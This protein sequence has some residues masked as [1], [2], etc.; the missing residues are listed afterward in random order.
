MKNVYVARKGC[1]CI[2]SAIVIQAGL[3]EPKTLGA[4]LKL[5]AEEGLVMDRVEPWEVE[6]TDACPHT[7]QASYLKDLEQAQDMTD[8]INAV[9]NDIHDG[10]VL[11]LT[12]SAIQRAARCTYTTAKQI[13]DRMEALNVVGPY[14]GDDRGQEVLIW[15]EPEAGMQQANPDPAAALDQAE[16][17]EDQPVEP[18]TGLDLEAAAVASN[19]EPDQEWQP[20]LPEID[21]VEETEV[22]IAAGVLAEDGIPAEDEL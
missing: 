9:M 1:G 16:A 2:V 5:W 14:R 18:Q 6:I 17:G 21:P 12:L 22:A 4:I 11:D 8:W 10:H 20:E 19:T 13:M 7:K 3:V 15:N